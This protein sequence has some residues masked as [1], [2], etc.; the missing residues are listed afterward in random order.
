MSKHGSASSMSTRKYQPRLVDNLVTR[1]LKE[2]PAL[3]LIGPRASGKTTTAVQYSKTVIRLDR[4]AEAIALRADPDAVLR[5]LPEPI[6][7]DEWQLVPSVLGAVKRSV[8]AESKPGRF[9]LTGSVRADIDSELWP[10]TGRI[11]RILLPTMSIREQLGRITGQSY[12]DRLAENRWLPVSHDSHDLR[13]YVELAIRSGFPEPALH[14]SQMAREPWLES[15]LD[16]T[17][18]RDAFA[19]DGGRNPLRLRRFFEALALNTAGI[20]SDKTLT[21]AAGINRKTAVAY[22][23]LMQNLLVTESIPAWSSN[24]L[25]RLIRAPKR[26]ISEPALVASA[27]RLDVNSILSDGDLLGRLLDTFVASQIRAELAI[28]ASKPRLFHVREE[29]GRH[30]ID[31][32][33]ELSG[34][35]VIAFEVKADSAPNTSAATHLNWL[36]N[37]LKDRFVIGVVLHTGPRVYSLGERICAAPISSLWA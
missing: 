21:D 18:T 19:I 34:Q 31:L 17:L 2:L 28:S 1:L 12:I 25:K 9:L 24:R 22:E 29:H 37:E 30:E 7:I 36:R 8:D 5:T 15:Y 27:L 4:E 3:L 26:Y 32:L 13:S 10:G 33:I 23:Q 6:L 11:V 16:Q 35:R 20:V 14:L